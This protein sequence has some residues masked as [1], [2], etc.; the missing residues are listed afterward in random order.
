M[1]RALSTGLRA[2]LRRRDAQSRAAL[3]PALANPEPVQLQTLLAMLRSNAQSTYG[4]ARDLAS[5]GTVREFQDA[6]PINSYEDLR[7]HIE[8]IADGSDPHALTGDRVE[9]FTSTSGTTSKPKLIPVTASGRRLEQRVKEA[10]LGAL[11]A[12]HPAITTG[13]WFY[14]FNNAEEERTPAGIWIGS[15]AGLVYRNSPP[16]LRRLLPM[17]YDVCLIDDYEA[18]Y[19]VILRHLL[20]TQVSMVACINPS[21]VLLLAELADQHAESLIR[22][23]YAGGLRSGLKLSREQYALFARGLPADPA[24]AR[25]LARM[26]S[27]DGALLPRRYWPQLDVVASWK[28][29]GVNS[30]VDKCR[31][32]YGDDMPFRDVGY[33]SS[34]FRTGLVRSDEGSRNLPLPDTYFYEFIPQAERDR[35][36]SGAQRPL[37]LHELEFGERYQI[38][39]TGPHGLYRYDIED[40][41]EVNGF[42]G[43]V[44]TISFV[45]KARTVT[46]IVGEKLYESHVVEA[47]ERVAAG[48]PELKPAFFICFADVESSC[49]RLCVEFDEPR[50]AAQLE[51]LG[52]RFDE[53]LGHVNVEYPYKRASLRLHAPDVHALQAGTAVR[54]IQH[55]GRSAVM[56]NQAKI[57]RLSAEVDA[58]FP[59]LGVQRR[60]RAHA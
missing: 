54:F 16:L 5:I 38:V 21:S 1:S 57:P 56:D 19:Y 53:E 50:T 58:Y 15:N 41:V 13:K 18:R 23:I 20:A 48:R 49:Y 46:S 28:G 26:H 39:Q 32:W 31:D 6:V 45:Q 59:V 27:E 25:A 37:L 11:A 17:P 14:L 44:P 9:M 30:F 3:Q 43:A 29:P 36:L 51:E 7:P 22:D 34:E 10:W 4:R 47:L 60:S 8:R 40:I 2:Y 33:G 52:R 42:E 55:I 24:R 35:C 12:D